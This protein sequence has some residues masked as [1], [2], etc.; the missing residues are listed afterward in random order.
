MENFAAMPEPLTKL[1]VCLPLFH[2]GSGYARLFWVMGVA[3]Y[4]ETTHEK[5]KKKKN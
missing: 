1:G 4:R 2:L 5:K 3:T